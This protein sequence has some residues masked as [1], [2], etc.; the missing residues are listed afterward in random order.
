MILIFWL[1]IYSSKKEDL[2]TW[3]FRCWKKAQ[4]WA[5]SFKII[6]YCQK[7]IQQPV[8]HP[9]IS[10]QWKFRQL[11]VTKIINDEKQGRKLKPVNIKTDK[12]IDQ[13]KF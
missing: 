8:K 11:K 10:Y 1:L 9:K 6:H 12:N 3:P 5:I 13:Q 2:D 4:K 7:R